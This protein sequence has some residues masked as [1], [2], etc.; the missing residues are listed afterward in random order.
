[1]S[2]GTE[3]KVFYF[4]KKGPENTDKTLEIA[5][6]VYSKPKSKPCCVC[7]LNDSCQKVLL[8]IWYLWVSLFRMPSSFLTLKEGF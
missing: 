6:A 4:E 8:F 7:R 5:V 1:M 3:K 2:N